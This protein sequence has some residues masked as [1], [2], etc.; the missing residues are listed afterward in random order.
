M[1]FNTN[2]DYDEPEYSSTWEL[3]PEPLNQL[4]Q[5]RLKERKYLQSRKEIIGMLLYNYVKSYPIV[6]LGITELLIANW[7]NRF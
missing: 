7:E 6:W 2:A 3:F 4:R 1:W 5:I